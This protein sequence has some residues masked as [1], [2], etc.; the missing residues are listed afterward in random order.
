ML[1]LSPLSQPF[2][3]LLLQ[4]LFGGLALVPCSVQAQCGSASILDPKPEKP[5]LSIAAVDNAPD[6]PAIW[7]GWSWKDVS[8][9]Y[10]KGRSVLSTFVPT[11]VGTSLPELGPT[12]DRLQ[13]AGLATAGVGLLVGP[14]MG[15]WCLGNPHVRGDIPPTLLRVAG[16]GGIAGALVWGGRLIDGADGLG[17]L[18]G[19][20]LKAGLITI[21]GFVAVTVGALWSLQKTPRLACDPNERD[22]SVSVTPTVES[23]SVGL[24]IRF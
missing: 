21:P 2:R 18:V 20:I 3:F 19:A 23:S 7:G 4:V 15:A 10:A 12:N 14:S 11:L 17:G 8:W 5:K 16:A 9:R 13:I 22:A 1:L 24:S 6:R